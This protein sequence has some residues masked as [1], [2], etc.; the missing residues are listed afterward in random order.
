M[1]YLTDNFLMTIKS[2]E[3]SDLM[4]AYKNRSDYSPE[5]EELIVDEVGF[6]GYD[7]AEI[8]KMSLK[9]ID[10]IVIRKKNSD[11]LIKIFYKQGNFKTGWD[12]L[13]KDELKCRGLVE[14]TDKPSMFKNVFSFNG[15]IRRLE[16]GLSIIIFFL[17]AILLGGIIEER[18][19]LFVLI[20]VYIF[21]LSQGTRRCHD[22]DFNGWWQLVPFFGFAML[23]LDGDVGSNQYGGN[24]KGKFFVL[25]NK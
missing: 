22:L 11:E 4:L 13:A 6:R 17:I 21:L 23:F 1:S 20:P 3:D 19:I 7:F 2:M 15:R 10:I 14:Q 8:E 18:F 5:F 9:D 12:E 16:Y 25:N 24:P